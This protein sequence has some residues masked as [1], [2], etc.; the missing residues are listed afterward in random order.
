MDERSVEPRIAPLVRTMNES[1][2]FTT[3]ASCQ[4]HRWKLMGPYVYF[5]SATATAATLQRLLREDQLYLEMSR[6][7]YVN[8]HPTT[9]SSAHD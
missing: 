6:V 7:Y 9:R 8:H 3:I 5:R 4:G 2:V 1:G